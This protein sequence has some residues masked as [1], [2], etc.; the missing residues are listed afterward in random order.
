MISANEFG[1][2][3]GN[4]GEENSRALQRALDLGGEITVCQPGVYDVS[5]TLF[6]G[7][8]TSLIFEDGVELRRVPSVTGRCGCA[9]LNRGALERKI[10]RNVR[11]S[12]LKLDCNGVESADW[13]AD[14]LMVG[15]RA[16]VGM[17]GIEDLF[18]ENCS[19]TGL[20]KKDYAFQVSA[21]ENIRIEDIFVSGDK[22]GVHL[23]W[24]RNFVI[25]RGRFCTFDDP[26]ALNAFDYSV[27]NTHVGW[28]ENGLIEDCVDLAAEDTTGFF[29]RIL[30]GAW[31]D[32]SE[33]MEVRHSDTVCSAGRVYRV[34]MAPDGEVYTSLTRPVHGSG[35]EVLDG[36]CWACVRDT[37]EY[38]CGCRNIVLRNIRLEKKRHCAVGISLNYDNYARSY[39]PGCAP[40]PQRD[41]TLENFSVEKRVEY[42]LRSDYPCGNLRIAN[43]DL[44]DSKIYFRDASLPGLVYP[45]VELALENVTLRENSVVSDKNHPV[46]LV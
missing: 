37:A 28:I 38:D 32:W 24:G 2:L 12:G 29:C 8:D 11:L 21:F 15:L 23:G 17:I 30:G 5:E 19:V 26:I 36:I 46:R 16:Q 1:F 40:V 22:D 25:R 6:P 18:I 14:S 34:V 43:T 39:V 7:D 35:T 45:E 42:M 3:P 4:K 33:G 27:S 44:K 41:I 9:F 20:L 31:V 10:N 13:G